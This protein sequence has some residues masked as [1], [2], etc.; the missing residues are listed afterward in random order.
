MLGYHKASQGMQEAAAPRGGSLS[1]Q[2]STSTVPSAAGQEAPP[3]GIKSG[4]AD[5]RLSATQE[6]GSS[7]KSH[8]GDPGMKLS[9][10]MS[11]THITGPAGQESTSVDENVGP[12]QPST[13]CSSA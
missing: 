11:G 6:T 8:L 9:D 1:Q 12:V 7:G 2:N 3:G 13:G 5:G 10:R 4:S